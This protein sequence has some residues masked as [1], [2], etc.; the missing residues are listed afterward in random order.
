MADLLNSLVKASYYW[1]MWTLQPKYLSSN[2]AFLLQNPKSSHEKTGVMEA[3]HHFVKHFMS[4]VFLLQST[5]QF[6]SGVLFCPGK[7]FKHTYHSKSTWS[8]Y[9]LNGSQIPSKYLVKYLC[10]TTKH[11]LDNGFGN[12]LKRY[13]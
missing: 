7:F 5:L 6:K 3:S 4:F 9:V 8:F 10:T 11:H 12:V 13:L 1:K 2:S